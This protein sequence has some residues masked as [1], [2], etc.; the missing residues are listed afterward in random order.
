MCLVYSIACKIWISIIGRLLRMWYRRAHLFVI[1]SFIYLFV[2]F[3]FCLLISSFVHTECMYLRKKKSHSGPVEDKTALRVCVCVCVCVCF[4]YYCKDLAQT[5]WMH[6]YMLIWNFGGHMFFW[7]SSCISCKS[8]F[9]YCKDTKTWI[10]LRSCTCM[11][12]LI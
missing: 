7:T 1:L 9:F 10:R 8:F 2:P 11:H 4:V 6:M 3:S 5:V 12:M